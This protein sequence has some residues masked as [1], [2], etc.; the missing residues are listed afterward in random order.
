[1]EATN[2]DMDWARTA[3]REL[4]LCIAVKLEHLARQLRVH[5]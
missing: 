3:L 1:M 4:L 5:E 2:D